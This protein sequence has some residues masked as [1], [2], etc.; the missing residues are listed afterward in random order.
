M[1]LARIMSIETLLDM[2]WTNELAKQDHPEE[3][4]INLVA[5]VDRAPRG[6]AAGRATASASGRHPCSE[7]AKTT[8][9]S[10][11]GLGKAG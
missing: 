10:F 7:S 9:A 6:G 8:A 11:A 1:L 3:E 4:A 2:I 5:Q